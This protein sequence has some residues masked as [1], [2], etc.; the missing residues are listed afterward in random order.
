MDEPSAKR[1]KPD[2]SESRYR[3]QLYGAASELAS[4]RNAKTATRQELCVECDT[5]PVTTPLSSLGLA[6]APTQWRW[7]CNDCVVG[8]NHL[9][10]PYV[11]P[12]LPQGDEPE[13]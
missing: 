13:E 2:A 6:K 9:K 7:R 5:C 3:S 12:M 4:R 8:W 1:V 10:R 11:P